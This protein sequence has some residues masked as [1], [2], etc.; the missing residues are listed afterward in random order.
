MRQEGI[1]KSSVSLLKKRVNNL[2]FLVH[3]FFLF[4]Q[5]ARLA[6][7][8]DNGAVMQDAVQDDGDDSDIAKGIVPME[9]SLVGG[10]YSGGFLIPSGNQQE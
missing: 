1:T 10:K 9:K 7:D 5:T 8:I 4:L 6:F 2:L 3:E